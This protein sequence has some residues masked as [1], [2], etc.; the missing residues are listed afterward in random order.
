[1]AI[2]LLR[3]LETSEEE[4][5]ETS[6]EWASTIRKWE[7]WQAG[8][9]ERQRQAE[10]ATK[11]QKRKGEDEE[12][13]RAESASSWEETFNPDDPSPQ[14]SFVG[15]SAYTKADLEDAIRDM[16]WVSIP[17][18]ALDALRRGIAVHHAGMNKA[19][20]SLVER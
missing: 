4:W 2:H 13:G 19:Y 18:W 7:R 9:K 17:Q 10:K 15:K 14:F 1:M 3:T 12:D 5:R 20:R 8:A 6:P 11:K 16:S